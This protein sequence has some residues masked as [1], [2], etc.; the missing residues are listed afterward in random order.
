M[1]NTWQ[2][3]F[4]STYTHTTLLHYTLDLDLDLHLHTIL[5]SIF[6]YICYRN[7][8]RLDLEI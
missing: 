5:A 6:A 1:P 4:I 3:C 2:P 7:P 8:N